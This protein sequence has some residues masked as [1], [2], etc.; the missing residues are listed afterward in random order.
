LESLKRLGTP[1]KILV[2]NNVAYGKAARECLGLLSEIGDNLNSP[3]Y[4]DLARQVDRSG[5]KFG[6]VWVDG[7]I[8][9]Y[10]PKYLESNRQIY[11]TLRIIDAEIAT[12]KLQEG[13]ENGSLPLEFF[14]KHYEQTGK[15]LRTELQM[16]LGVRL[17]KDEPV[18]ALYGMFSDRNESPIG[19]VI[20]IRDIKFNS[21]NYL[22]NPGMPVDCW[23][24]NLVTQMEI[25]VRNKF[26]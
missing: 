13:F 10:A 25:Q 12:K 9:P 19:D 16:V 14:R 8:K 20:G 18:D 3:Y 23:C 6:C 11:H 24:G 17:D 21:G 4:R 26:I 1:K 7:F 15:I 22:V 2:E 5:Y